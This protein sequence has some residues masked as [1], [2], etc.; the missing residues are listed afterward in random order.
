VDGVVIFD[1]ENP[2]DTIKYLMPDILVKGGDWNEDEI[3]GADVV[4]SA[5]GKVMRIAFVPGYSTTEFIRKIRSQ[6]PTGKMNGILPT[7]SKR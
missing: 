7:P 3:I 5:G 6:I 1:A 4:K 2:L